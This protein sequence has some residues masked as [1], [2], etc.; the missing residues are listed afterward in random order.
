VHFSKSAIRIGSP[1]S[2]I[3]TL[4]IANRGEIACR[5]IRTCKH[6]DIRTVAVYSDAD[7]DALFV[8]QADQ[9][10]HIGGSRPTESYLNL[11]AIMIAAQA[12]GADAIHPGYGFLSENPEFPRRC[13]KAGLLFVGPSAETMELMGSKAI[14]KE[15]MWAAGVPIVPGYQGENQNPE[16][17]AAEAKQLGFPLMIKAA[18]GGGGKGMRIVASAEHFTA[19]LESAQREAKNAFGDQRMILERYLDTPRHVEVQVFGDTH[20]NVVHLFERDCSSQRRYQKII[21]E[22]PAPGLDAVIV[23]AMREAAVKAAQAVHYVNAGTIEFIVSA[24]GSFYFMEMNTRLQVEHPVT[25]MITGLDLV[26]LQLRISS[27]E[28]IDVEQLP[29]R[30]QGHAIEARIYAEDPA[31]GFL[32][33]SGRIKWLQFPA[34]ARADS[35]V[36][37]GGEVTVH[38]DPLI[39][40]LIVHGQDRQQ[41]LAAMDQAL[42]STVVFGPSSNIDFLSTLINSQQLSA[43]ALHTAYLDQE[44]NSIYTPMD[45]PPTAALLAASVAHLMDQEAASLER[46]SRS[47]DPNSPWGIS[48]GWRIGHSGK[49]VISFRYLD[50]HHQIEALGH[51][52]NYSLSIGE[53]CHRIDEAWWEGDRLHV[54]IEGQSSS[55]LV[56]HREPLFQVAVKGRIIQLTAENPFALDLSEETTHNQV[57][58]PMPGRIVNVAVALGDQVIAGQQIIVMEAMKMELSL[59]AAMDGVIARIDAEEGAFVEADRVLVELED[60][61]E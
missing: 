45:V 15:T 56:L 32:P 52:G 61:I 8:R 12:S 53:T 24:N 43:G 49:R 18:A 40:K 28:A 57:C 27:G 9:A 42:A 36:H 54:R 51:D 55:A 20:G 30:P 41:A 58:A 10:I 47:T 16:H 46:Q 31:T 21:E 34:E 33:S 50:V 44:L 4:L 37:E 22:A 14:A 11:D 23:T 60:T 5:I 25:E 13:S 59:T 48:D 6:L 1:A 17:L 39:A 29:A 19:A 35:G 2:M 26:E 7:V 3:K 38:Y